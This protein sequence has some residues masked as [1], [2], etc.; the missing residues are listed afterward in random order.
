MK[1]YHS[2]VGGAFFHGLAAAKRQLKE[3]CTLETSV[4]ALARFVRQIESAEK[5]VH[6]SEQD[7]DDTA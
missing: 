1:R 3:S 2:A 6:A 5:T 7:R 4:S